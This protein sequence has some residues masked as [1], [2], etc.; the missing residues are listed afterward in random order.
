MNILKVL[1]T[2]VGSVIALFIMTKIIGNKQ[3]SQ[4]NLFDY[5]N[6]ITIGSIAAEL[7]ITPEAD[8]YQPLIA[9]IVYTIVTYLINV[10]SSKSLKLRRFLEGK[11]IIL[12]SNNKLYKENFKKANLDINE[13]LT[14]CRVLGYYNIS[15]INTAIIE[16]NG[17]I[18]VLPNENARPVTLR[19]MNI[20]SS[21]SLVQYIVIVD[22]Y[23][24][25]SN[26]SA[27]GF[28]K[29]WLDKQ[30][31][32]CKLKLNEVYLGICDSN[33]KANFYEYARESGADPFQ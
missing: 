12:M 33:G 32:A 27:L 15:D 3:V 18:S 25:E 17:K 19:D 6:G 16:S 22:G 29:E 13:F 26:L 2:S 11:S 9:L 5:I 20:N 28:D 10:C 8:F 14:Q 23:I 30:L 4:L 31:K 24:A 7:A 21:Q 1:L